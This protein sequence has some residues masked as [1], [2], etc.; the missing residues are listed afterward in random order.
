MQF[1]LGFI[2]CLLLIFLILFLEAFVLVRKQ[3]T[4]TELVERRLERSAEGRAQV[5]QPTPSR[6][7]LMEERIRANEREGRETKLNDIYYED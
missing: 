6:V 5:I 2:A 1:F 4:V 3:T 7:E